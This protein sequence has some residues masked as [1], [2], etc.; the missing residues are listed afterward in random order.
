M[1]PVSRVV[2]SSIT[3]LSLCLSVAAQAPQWK[4]FSNETDGFRA[5]FPTTPELTR[6]SVPIGGDVY[7]LHSY[8]AQAG[9]TS[10]YIGVCDYGAK[11]VAADPDELLGSAKQGVVDDMKARILREKRITLDAGVGTAFEAE[12]DTTHSS[13]RMVLSGGALYQI[14]ASTP[15]SEKFAESERFLDSLELIPPTRAAD[16][17]APSPAEW[18]S[19]PYPGDGFSAA[20][21]HQP[22][23]ER[24][25]VSADT[26]PFD[27]RTYVA[28]DGS[29][30]LIAAV[31]DYGPS[32]AGKDPDALI[33][34]AKA[35]AVR[36]LK[37]HLLSEKK[38]AS[39][40]HHG[41]AFEAESESD[42]ISARFYMAGQFL[43]QTIV[44]TPVKDNY[45]DAGRFLDSFTVLETSKP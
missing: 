26:G 43:Y 12:S 41:V 38:L 42:H 3:A 15:R 45:A 19:Y 20:F 28:E 11:G 1:R 40:A 34:S 5:L 29:A 4:Q 33:E 23:I 36:N 14:M 8:T 17:P 2:V 44:I 13:V 30:S 31:C 22:S 27:L 7:E 35:G 9:S 39:D 18:K 6:K 16:G 24:Q 25:T 21:P 10:L 32:A 37:A